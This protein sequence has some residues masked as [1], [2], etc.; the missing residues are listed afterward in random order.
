MTAPAFSIGAHINNLDNLLTSIGCHFQESM[1]FWAVVAKQ[2]CDKI[3][4]EDNLVRLSRRLRSVKY[5][6]F[7]DGDYAGDVVVSPIHSWEGFK[8]SL[9]LCG[10]FSLSGLPT[11]LG[12]RARL[13]S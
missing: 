11:G 7:A 13:E 5:Q 4:F 2:S 12:R 9:F 6:P 8:H 10:Y 1:N 3:R